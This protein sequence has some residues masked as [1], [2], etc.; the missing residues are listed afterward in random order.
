MKYKQLRTLVVVFFINGCGGSDEGGATNADSSVIDS[1]EVGNASLPITGDD[2]SQVIEGGEPDNSQSANSTDVVGVNGS[3]CAGIDHTVVYEVFQNL[4]SEGGWYVPSGAP[5]IYGWNGMEYCDLTASQGVQTV[6]VLVPFVATPPTIDGVSHIGSRPTENGI[7]RRLIEWQNAARAT[8]STATD[9][10][11]LMRNLQDGSLNG[12]QDQARAA[13]I[14]LLHDGVY[15]YVNVWVQ[16]DY[17]EKVYM[18]SIDPADDDSLEVFIDADNSRAPEYDGVND[19]HSQLVYQDTTYTPV[20]GDNSAPG[21]QLDYKTWRL[22]TAPQYSPSVYELRIHLASA[23]IEPGRP[24][25]FE[26]QLNED[27]NG[28]PGD[29]RF[30]WFEPSGS[31]MASS[32]PSVFGTIVLTGCADAAQ[33]DNVQSLT[34]E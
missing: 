21:L 2:A 14:M 12:Y 20:A 17:I 11:L 25:G 24:F 16:N 15:L 4:H 9:S 6:D 27:D 5:G 30:G 10:L 33:C 31:N 7:S 13:D 19:F 1:G 29:A 28:G 18:D 32:N 3:V 8:W 26:L 23:G 22:E 34:G